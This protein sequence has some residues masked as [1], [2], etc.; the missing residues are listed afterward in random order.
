MSES[1]SPGAELRAARERLGLSLPEVASALKVPWAVVSDIENEQ[2]DAL[3]PRVFARAYLRSYAEIVGISPDALLRAYDQNVPPDATGS[4]GTRSRIALGLRPVPLRDARL[5]RRP[6]WVFGGTVVLFA[7]LAGLFL[8]F[9]WPTDAPIAP[10]PGEERSQAR[11]ADDDG[12]QPASDSGNAV[13]D[14]AS[15]PVESELPADESSAG[16]ETPA[17]GGMPPSV[18]SDAQ[19]STPPDDLPDSAFAGPDEGPFASPSGLTYVPGA[20]Q[21]LV[22]RFTQDCWVRVL[23]ASGAALHSGLERAGSE[24]E[25]RGEAPF[26][27][28]LGYAPGVLLEYNGEPVMLAQHTNDSDVAELVLGL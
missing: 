15:V 1:E 22:F 6:S 11:A 13:S 10:A 17:S 20:D 4:A 26:T 16:G 14:V 8:W 23:D 9:A 12:A 7:V 24:L 5:H 21:A 3:P 25:V 2:F 28:T 27:L 19:P 18:P